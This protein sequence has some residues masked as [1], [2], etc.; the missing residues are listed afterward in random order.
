LTHR[1]CRVW[2]DR[3]VPIPGSVLGDFLLIVAFSYPTVN[4]KI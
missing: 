3:S 4:R 1:N 2:L